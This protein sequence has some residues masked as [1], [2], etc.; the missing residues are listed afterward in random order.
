MKRCPECD[1]EVYSDQTTGEDI[2][3]ECGLV[4]NGIKF[5]REEQRSG[6]VEDSFHESQKNKHR[7]KDMTKTEFF[8]GSSTEITSE[9]NGN[10]NQN[11]DERNRR[12]RYWNWIYRK[13][14]YRDKA[15]EKIVMKLK[16][17]CSKLDMP[18]TSIKEVAN[19]YRKCFDEDLTQGVLEEV[20]LASVIYLVCRRDNIPV[21]V[22]ELADNVDV[23]TKQITRFYNRLKKE[24]N[25]L[26]PPQKYE[27][28]VE[29]YSS[30]LDVSTDVKLQAKKIV[31]EVECEMVGKKPSGV[32]GGCLYLTDNM[33]NGSKE[34]VTQD[35]VAEKY[36]VCQDTIRKR[37][38]EIKEI[39]GD[40]FK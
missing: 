14:D 27:N 18:T 11:Q 33:M 37:K 4:V 40:E 21:S 25:V 2:C 23:C 15:F 20:V 30:E 38:N 3:S 26:I 8:S 9:A 34:S 35:E 17:L 36:N 12:I 16:T 5:N 22:D 10:V 29:R 39:I 19:Y 13:S 31:N 24:F 32:A 7:G 28:F 6:D 1:G